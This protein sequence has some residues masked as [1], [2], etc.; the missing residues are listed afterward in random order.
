MCEQLY[1]ALMTIFS[2]SWA[3]ELQE[4]LARGEMLGRNTAQAP[5]SSS[6]VG[7][8]KEGSTAF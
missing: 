4:G 6:T 8:W 2:F 3:R 7:E 5:V 1:F